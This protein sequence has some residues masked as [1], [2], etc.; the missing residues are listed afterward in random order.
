V[1][2]TGEGKRCVC[3]Q[4]D[5]CFALLKVQTSLPFDEKRGKRHFLFEH[6]VLA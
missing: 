1:F 3:G 2:V 4:V 5:S 6:L